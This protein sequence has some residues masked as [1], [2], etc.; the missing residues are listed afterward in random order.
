MSLH[1]CELRW[2]L[3]TPQKTLL[4]LPGSPSPLPSLPPHR[5]YQDDL[6]HTGT[7]VMSGA[8]GHSQQ[9]GQAGSSDPNTSRH[10]QPLLV[11]ATGPHP[12]EAWPV[13]IILRHFLTSGME[14]GGAGHHRTQCSFRSDEVGFRSRPD[15]GVHR[16]KSCN[17]HIQGGEK[18][19]KEFHG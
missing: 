11:R 19:G 3:V 17:R 15:L 5:N 9:A 12:P 13:V 8:A 16:A 10:R 4:G 2:A 7:P 14:V 18:G 1:G 6:L